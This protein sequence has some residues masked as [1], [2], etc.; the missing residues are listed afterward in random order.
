[1]KDILALISKTADGV[2]AV[3]RE[4]RIVF[5]ND[6]AAALLGLSAQEALGRFCYEVIGGRDE[7][8][9]LVCHAQCS[10][11]ITALR[12]ELVLTHDLVV[13]TK[14]GRELVL[15]V[16]TIVVPSQWSDLFVLVHLFRDVSRQK[17]VQRFAQHLFSIVGKLSL[18]LATEPLIR[19]PVSSSSMNLT[20]RE[21]E[22]LRLLAS[23][24]STEAIAKQL[25]I[26][27]STV[28]NHITSILAK[29][30]VR[31]RLEAVTLALRSGLL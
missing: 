23:G 13:R 24:A 19:P 18:P 31:S 3:D 11:L 14:A 25:F 2:F 29:L 8:G 22:V 5:W 10:I 30:D 1:M 21:R 20:G 4:Q 16:S 17:E 9:Q 7:S 15:N 26:S 6:A 28:R 27:P 12:Q